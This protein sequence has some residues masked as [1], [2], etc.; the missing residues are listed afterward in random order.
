MHFMGQGIQIDVLKQR[1][2]LGTLDQLPVVLFKHIGVDPV[3]THPVGIVVTVVGHLVDEEQAQHLDAPV[4]QG[5]FLVQVL[6][7]GLADLLLLDGPVVNVAYSLTNPQEFRLSGKTDILIALFT[8]DV[9][10]HIAAVH[11]PVAGQLLG[12]IIPL[13][14][15]HRFAFDCALD[16]TVQL[17][18]GRDRGFL[19]IHRQQLHVCLVVVVQTL[20]AGDLDLFHQ[21]Q[22]KGVHRIQLVHQVVFLHMGSG[23]AQGTQGVQRCHRLLGGRRSFALYA[24]RLVHDNHRVGLLDQADRTHPVELVDGPVD[25]IGLVFLLRVI[26]ALSESGDVDDHDGNV[27]IDGKGAHFLRFA[28]VVDVGVVDHI[29]I[30]G[31]E[32]FLGDLQGLGH[33]LLDGDAGHHDDEL[34]EAVGLVQFKDGAQ[35][36]IGLA[37]AS[38]HLDVKVIGSLFQRL[39]LGQAIA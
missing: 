39:G 33:A 1:P 9:V 36:H 21:F 13:A 26:K 12:E 28:A 2:V 17:Y 18:F 22:V 19:V 31:L 3:V 25:D 23:V 20:K 4:V 14:H 27:V 7:D 29:V 15:G 34:L 10:H 30:D 35:V 11:F 38:L 8:I 5:Q 32:V 24:L 6:L 37:S 16:L